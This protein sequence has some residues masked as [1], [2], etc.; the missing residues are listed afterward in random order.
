[1]ILHKLKHPAFLGDFKDLKQNTSFLV[2]KKFFP[3]EGIFNKKHFLQFC[4]SLANQLL[5]LHSHKFIHGDIK[6]SNIVLQKENDWT[7][8]LLIDFDNSVEF[9][10]KDGVYINI[11]T[12]EKIELKK[13]T[14]GYFPPEFPYCTPKSDVYSLG[15]TF[16]ALLLDL[17]YDQHEQFKPNLYILKKLEEVKDDKIIPYVEILKKMICTEA[18]AIKSI[19]SLKKE[20]KVQNTSSRIEEKIPMKRKFDVPKK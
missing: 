15:I 9:D 7:T 2:L 3:T 16:S 13:D 1:M 4:L 20:S 17:R 12:N 6:I 8:P 5:E 18:K 10:I 14:H 19:K 11:N